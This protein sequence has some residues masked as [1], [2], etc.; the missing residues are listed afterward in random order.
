M[1]SPVAGHYNGEW[2]KAERALHWLHRIAGSDSPRAWNQ[3]QATP[4]VK[5]NADAVKG[6]K[7]PRALHLNSALLLCQGIGRC[8][9]L[10]GT[11][12][13]EPNKTKPRPAGM[14][15]RCRHSCRQRLPCRR[16]AQLQG[17][18]F[19]QLAWRPHGSPLGG[20]WRAVALC[21]HSQYEF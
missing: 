20:R 2:R 16:R 14:V 21:N 19:P 18:A 5:M 4:N 11:Y 12:R 13:G 3:L 10:A 1:R 15:R 8:S 6:S 9:C 17:G 7:N